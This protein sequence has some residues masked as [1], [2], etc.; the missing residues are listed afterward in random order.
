MEDR[1]SFEPNEINI[2]NILSCS[3]KLSMTEE[4]KICELAEVARET[5]AFVKA[6]LTD[7]LNVYEAFSVLSETVN[8]HKDV[9]F[10][11]S[12]E[13]NKIHLKNFLHLSSV[14]DRSVFCSLL[15]EYLISSGM[16]ISEQSF[17]F[18]N[19]ED[20]T[21]VY[22]KNQFSDEAYDVFSQE[23]SDPRVKY[24]DSFKEAVRLVADGSVSFCLLPIEERGVR[25]PTVEEL[26][27]KTDSKINSVTPVFGYDG[28]ADLKYAL[29]SKN[30][31]LSDFT[32]ED[33]RY[34]EIRLPFDSENLSALMVC[35]EEFDFKLFRVNT[36]SF[37]NNDDNVGYFSVVLK[38]LNGDFTKL[39]V[40]L[41]LF[42][43]EYIPVGIYKNLE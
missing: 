40:F 43:P 38:S 14:F 31:Y 30:I 10:D 29:V 25:L 34:F 18:D 26:I 21:F 15:I 4:Q 39:L 27:S 16:L 19:S 42:V 36:V 12:L 8:I 7:G 9:C 22:V 3:V 2:S 20:E 5:A 41:T 6:L 28:L 11:E 1:Y 32:S 23:F 37:K 13:D 17:F 33:D 35:A 24:A